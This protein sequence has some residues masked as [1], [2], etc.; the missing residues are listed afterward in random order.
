ME[1]Y[2]NTVQR[3]TKALNDLID[4]LIENEPFWGQGEN[5]EFAM[6][7]TRQILEMLTPI[8]EELSEI[9]PNGKN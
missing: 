5:Y 8:A 3:T 1:I 4:R 7:T 2:K 6:Y 9:W